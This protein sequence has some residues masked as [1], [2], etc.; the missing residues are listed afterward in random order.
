MRRTFVM[1]LSLSSCAWVGPDDM[2]EF[3]DRDSD[4]FLAGDFP[5]DALV[6]SG[7]Q[8][9]DCDDDDVAVYPNAVELCNGKDDDCDDDVDEDSA[10]DAKTWFIDG[11]GD[12]FGHKDTTAVSCAKPEGY[13]DNADDCDD[14]KELIHPGAPE[15]CNGDDDDCN[16]KTD[17]EDSAVDPST[18]A[19]GWPDDD[20]DGV[21]AEQ[22][23]TRACVLPEG[24]V[25]TTGDCDDVDARVHPGALEVCD[26]VD[27]DCDGSGDIDKTAGLRLPVGSETPLVDLTATLGA[28]GA[29]PYELSTQGAELAL[30][31]GS[32]GVALTVTAD[33]SI[34]GIGEKAR[35]AGGNVVPTISITKPVELAITNLAVQSGKAAHED[36]GT[37]SGG[38]VT[39]Y[40]GGARGGVGANVSLTDVTVEGATGNGLGLIGTVNLNNVVVRNHSRSG[41]TLG[42]DVTLRDVI[43]ETNRDYG[44][45]FRTLDG[46]PTELDADRVISRRNGNHAFNWLDMQGTLRNATL[47]DNAWAGL[48][49]GGALTDLV[50]EDAVIQRNGGFWGSGLYLAGGVITLR[51]V[52]I[53]DNRATRGAG[54]YV[55]GTA[56]FEDV[57]MEDNTATDGAGLWIAGTVE[58]TSVDGLATIKNNVGTTG[59]GV[60]IN[61][62]SKLVLTNVDVDDNTPQDIWVATE[63]SFDLSGKT[64]MTCQRGTPYCK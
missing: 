16:G 34:R 45:A 1:M 13:A 4:D 25:Q 42:G 56:T 21:G 51:R 31:G 6:P 5:A 23:A 8:R 59:G 50:V 29:T 39:T 57:R 14:A 54:A 9:G 10:E 63:E 47:E 49:G 24:H 55:A 2:A 40:E 33:A 28:S 22:D 19:E 30:C 32:W 48:S 61:D 38:G 12:D 17:D 53:L 58:F 26:G 44:V 7:K 15:T 20:G 64:S 46:S 52:D 43:F 62:G 60:F 11:D 18:F 37:D 41:A 27:D 36:Y 3:Y 35:L